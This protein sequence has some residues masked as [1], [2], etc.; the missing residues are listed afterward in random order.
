MWANSYMDQVQNSAWSGWNFEEKR[1]EKL[2]QKVYNR[3]SLNLVD[4]H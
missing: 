2:D 1:E 3:N 4:H